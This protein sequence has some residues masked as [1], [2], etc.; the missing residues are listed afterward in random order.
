MF[1]VLMTAPPAPVLVVTDAAI[2]YTC[3]NATFMDP[4]PLTLSLIHI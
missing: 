1:H 3:R 4:A 2:R